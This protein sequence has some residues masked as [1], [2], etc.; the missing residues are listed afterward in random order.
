MQFSNS[1]K[2]LAKQPSTIQIQSTQ[3][4]RKKKK[5][6]NANDNDTFSQGTTALNSQIVLPSLVYVKA[7]CNHW[8][9]LYIADRQADKE[10][11]PAPLH[12]YLSCHFRHAEPVSVAHYSAHLHVPPDNFEWV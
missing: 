12:P 4:P 8:Y 10:S 11:P 2:C 7:G 5:N 3:T 9:N 1:V 6:A